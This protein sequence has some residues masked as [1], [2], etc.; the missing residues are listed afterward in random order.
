M[1]IRNSLQLN[2]IKL[3]ISRKDIYYDLLSEAAYSYKLFSFDSDE[4]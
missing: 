4:L 3:I 1:E 2:A